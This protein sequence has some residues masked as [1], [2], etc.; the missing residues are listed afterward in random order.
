ME[1]VVLV[2]LPRR[3]S[4]IAWSNTDVALREAQLWTPMQEPSSG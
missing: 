4:F 1:C 3:G 2:R